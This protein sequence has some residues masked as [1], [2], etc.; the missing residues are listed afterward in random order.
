MHLSFCWARIAAEYEET[1]LLLML[2]L[3]KMAQT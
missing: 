1:M 2:E 3:E